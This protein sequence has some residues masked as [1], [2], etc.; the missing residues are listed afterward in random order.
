[1]AVIASM[2]QPTMKSLIGSAATKGCSQ[3]LARFFTAI[4]F[5]TDD[6]DG[7]LLP[8]AHRPRDPSIKQMMWFELLAEY[9][10]N[11][12]DAQMCP[13]TAKKTTRGAWGTTD[14]SW[15]WGNYFG[16]YAYN[17]YFHSVYYRWGNLSF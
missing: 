11:L 2:I 13:S 6:Y 14:V 3:N 8:Y 15:K 16:S 9:N 1:M 10:E 4:S 12:V 5:Y 17:S 7:H